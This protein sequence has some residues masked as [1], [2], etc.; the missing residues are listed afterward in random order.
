MAAEAAARERD[1][2]IHHNKRTREWE[3]EEG[4]G[5]GKKPASEE[6]RARMDDMRHHRQSPPVRVTSPHR[7]ERRRSSSERPREDYH[8]GPPPA[9]LHTPNVPPVLGHQPLPPINDAPRMSEP[10][11]RITE[12]HRM[13]EAP[14]DDRKEIIEPAARK[15]ELDEDYDDEG[16]GDADRNPGAQVKENNSPAGN[17]TNGI[18]GGGGAPGDN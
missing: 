2:K 8:H 18:S 9:P 11:P 14:R 16:M 6:A 12:A 15:V 7:P 17:G 13:S 3:E 4:Q 1:E 5:I 10:P